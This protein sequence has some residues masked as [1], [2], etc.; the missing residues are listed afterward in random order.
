MTDEARRVAEKPSARKQLRLPIYPIA[1]L[2]GH[3][4]A[5]A[6]RQEQDDEHA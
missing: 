3:E 2:A 6:N 1:H 5:R 4:P